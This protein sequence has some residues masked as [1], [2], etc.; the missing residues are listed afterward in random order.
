[1]NEIPGHSLP[2]YSEEAR[3]DALFHYTSAN[4]LIGILQNKEIWSTASYCTNDESE[5]AA[6]KGILTS[7]FSLATHELIQTND[8]LVRTFAARGVDISEYARGFEQKITAHALSSACAYI[9][10]FCKPNEA[11][12][13]AHGLLSQWRAYGTDGGYALQFSRKKLLAAI[14]RVNNDNLIY[15][16]QDVHYTPENP[17]KSEVLSHKDAFLREYRALLEELAQP[18]EKLLSSNTAR[19]PLPGLLNGPLE[20][21]LDYLLHTK[22]PHFGEEKECRL[23]LL[24]LVS[25]SAEALPTKYF[26]RGGTIIPYKG[27][28]DSFRILE[29]IDWILIGP[30]PRMSARFKS[31]S[32]M[33]QR[34]GLHVG[35][36]PSHI[37]F[38]RA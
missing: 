20:S 10:C 21:L 29:C 30:N 33:V 23:S 34:A 6:G 25:P 5:L 7:L 13:F 27:T 17:I 1:M 35:I 3:N 8:P 4:G 28:P 15:Q 32:Q 37:P 18:L 19:S 9:T 38:T 2:R 12:D 16:L 22:N 26:N 24:E 14:E 36:R 11:E 31:V